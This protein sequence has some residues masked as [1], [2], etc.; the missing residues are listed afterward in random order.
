MDSLLAVV[1]DRSGGLLISQR[2]MVMSTIGKVKHRF[3]FDLECPDLQVQWKSGLGG[4]GFLHGINVMFINE[5]EIIQ[6]S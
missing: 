3:G 5:N 4:P 1:F 2:M 6:P